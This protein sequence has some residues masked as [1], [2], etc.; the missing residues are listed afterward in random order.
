MDRFFLG[1]SFFFVFITLFVFMVP[2]GRLSWLPV[3]SWA[4]VDIHRD[5]YNT[6]RYICDHNYGKTRLIFIIFALLYGGRTFYTYMK[7]PVHLT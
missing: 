1:I 4:Q 6:W 7:K 3:G 2:C 5:S